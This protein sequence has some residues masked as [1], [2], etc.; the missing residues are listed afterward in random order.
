MNQL[1]RSRVFALTL[2]VLLIGAAACGKRYVDGT[3]PQQAVAYEVDQTLKLMKGAQETVI[4]AV[5]AKPELKPAA[6]KFLDPVY[7]LAKEVQDGRLVSTLQAWDA[8]D[9]L[10]DEAKKVQIETD[11]KPLLE[12]FYTLVNEAIRAP[13]PGELTNAVTDFVVQAQR[14]LQILTGRFKLPA[15]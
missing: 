2:L 5:D 10:Q 13:L 15:Q 12:Q 6:D 1:T 9:K 14:T 11:L 8:A 7:K 3:T 4:A